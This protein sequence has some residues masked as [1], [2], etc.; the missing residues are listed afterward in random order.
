MGFPDQGSDLSRSFDLSRSCGNTK[1]LA[2][3]AGLGSE[4]GS[5]CSQEAANAAAPQQELRHR[6]Q[7]FV[8][9]DAAVSPVHT[10]E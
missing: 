5:R 4:P 3:C 2:H 7:G 10:L 9:M 8:W 1:S 6:V